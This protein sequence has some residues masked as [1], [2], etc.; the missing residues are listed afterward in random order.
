MKIC[1]LISSIDK[2][3]AETHLYSLIKQQIKNKDSVTVIY[4]KGNNY[5]KKFYNKIGVKAYRINLENFINI[6]FLVKTIIKISYHI[7]TI[8]P[9]IVHAHLSAMELIAALIKFLT[10]NRFKLVITKHLDSF[11]FE[12]SF[13]KRNFFNGLSFDRFIFSQ[14]DKIICISKQVRKYFLNKIKSSNS[15]LKVI[16][17]GFSIKDFNFS[18]DYKNKIKNFKKKY[19]IKKNDLI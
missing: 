1:H 8:K 18:K 2:G 5:W 10:K 16:Y 4:L 13:G 11:F 6:Y 15:K 3:G 7:K 12:A 19:K 17:Y 9:Q 14:S